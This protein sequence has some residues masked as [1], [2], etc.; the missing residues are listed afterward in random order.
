M[1]EGAWRACGG[2]RVWVMRW[3]EGLGGPPAAVGD[4]EGAA[5]PGC[6]AGVVVLVTDG[7]GDG[8]RRWW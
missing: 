6:W 3:R 7:G 4:R 8:D 5:P 1:G 2:R